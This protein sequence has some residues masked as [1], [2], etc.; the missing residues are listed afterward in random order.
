MFVIGDRVLLGIQDR[1][2]LDAVIGFANLTMRDSRRLEW[3]MGTQRY[4][5]IELD[6]HRITCRN[7]R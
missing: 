2:A 7:R 4:E 5:K 6:F 3:Q 1:T